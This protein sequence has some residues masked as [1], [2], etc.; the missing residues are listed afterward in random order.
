MKVNDLERKYARCWTEC[1]RCQGSDHLEV[2][3]EN[4]DCRIFY[5][6]IKV[7]TDLEEQR[8]IMARFKE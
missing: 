3:C 7:K 4:M 8:K 6:R 2:I 1:Q 5:K